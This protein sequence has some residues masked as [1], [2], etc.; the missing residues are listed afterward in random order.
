MFVAED[1]RTT[2]LVNTLP[3]CGV[4]CYRYP[5][6]AKQKS[7]WHSILPRGLPPSKFTL[8]E[9]RTAKQA[10]AYLTERVQGPEGIAEYISTFRFLLLFGIAC[11]AE[12]KYPPLTRCWK[13]LE[14]LF[15]S[16]AI[17]DDGV[18]VQSWILM[19]FPFG[20]EGQTAHRLLRGV[21]GRYRCGAARRAVHRRS[22]QESPRSSS[23]HRANQDWRE[24]S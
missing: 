8:D 18:F 5:S 2:Q 9:L 1:L 19:D 3:V 4:A 16:E 23:R 13:D 22:A 15:M 6:M 7:A 20:P 10:H 14:K 17:F 12:D 11:V 21:L 24:V